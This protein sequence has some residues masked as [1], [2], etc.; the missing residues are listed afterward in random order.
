MTMRR[1][2]LP[3]CACWITAPRA[4]PLP[5]FRRAFHLRLPVR[6]AVVSICGLG[7]FELRLNGAKAG[8]DVLEPGWTD[9][10]KTCLVV[11]HDVTSLLRPGEN[12]V[13]VLLGNG[14]FNVTGGR[15]AKFKRTFGSPCLIA[16]LRI[17]H[18]DGETILLG[19]DRSWR[20]APGPITFS[21]IY[22]GEDH[23][24]RLEPVGWDLPGFDDSGWADVVP[25]D[26]PGGQLVEVPVPPIRV[27]ETRSPI[28]SRDIAPGVRVFD[29][30]QNLSGRPTLRLR[31]R[32]GATLTLRPGEL[33]DDAGRVCQKNIGQ[34]TCFTYTA[35]GDAREEWTPRFSYSGFRYLQAEG[36]LDTIESV[37]AA[38]THA[39]ARVIGTF[40][41]SDQRFNRVH[42]IILAAVR[43]NMQSVLTDCPHR[44]KLGWLEQTHLMGPS[45]LCNYDLA[46]LYA[47]ISRDMRDAQHDDG[48]VP[49][50]APRYTRFEAP[51]DVFNDSPEWGSAI[52]QNPW[53]VYR[54]T[55]RT[56][57]VEE[58]YDAMTRYVAYLI[59]RARNGI[60]EYGLGDW[61]DCGEGR[62]GFSRL[63]TLGLTA[64]AIYFDDLVVMQRCAA[65]LGRHD[66]ASRYAAL[67][68]QAR[69]AF[70]ERFFDRATRRYDTASQTACAMPL[71]LG[72]VEQEHRPLVLRTLFEDIAAH[73]NHFTAGDI[74]LRY[75]LLA[76][77][78][79]GRSDIV[80]EVLRR[81]DP[82]GYGHMIARGATTL[83][84]A[85][86]ADRGSSQNHFMLGHVEEWFHEHLAGIR[87]DF[88]RPAAAQVCIAPA[89]VPGMEWVEASRETPLGHVVV[90]WERRGSRVRL[91]A[92]LP[93]DA[94]LRW[95]D[96][97]TRVLPAGEHQ[98]ETP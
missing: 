8:Q 28:A 10:G 87:V 19:S 13:G 97:T 38:W 48:M 11:V 78:E 93:R 30:G 83:T 91:D 57:L 25:C 35:R 75:V 79:A 3:G 39:S 60:I 16:A 21:C 33:L 86:D 14:M 22:G 51:W 53:L 7:H 1:D 95:P 59:A 23:D 41:C 2:D 36:D 12:V 68:S 32:P 54:H 64:T 29:L 26:G 40:A 37:S 24:A 77:A 81:D 66:E 18:D 73:G 71:V 58:N 84:E 56:D 50:I 46:S 45:L 82:P 49:T 47:K 44:E 9:Y 92:T 20:T 55:G 31:G 76:L 5:L 94:E 70:N 43:S 61:Y 4:T 52:V 98:L 88:A 89:F 34:P 42:E 72:L 90:R 62:P 96:G 69:R 17:E 6:R 67:A 80:A 15:Y 65:M 63:T 27:T 74:G 85:W